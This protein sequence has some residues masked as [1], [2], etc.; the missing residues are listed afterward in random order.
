MKLSLIVLSLLLS[1]CHGAGRVTDSHCLIDKPILISR[2]QDK[3]SEQTAQDILTH[4]E[5]W[6]RLC[7]G[8]A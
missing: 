5:K 2:S 6:A 8:D 7:R 1:A 4:N 3:L